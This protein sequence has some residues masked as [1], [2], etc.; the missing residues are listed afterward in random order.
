M[1]KLFILAALALAMV[2]C[3]PKEPATWQEAYDAFMEQR[4][5]IFQDSTLTEDQQLD[6][7]IE[8][9]LKTMKKHMDDTLG[10][11]L[12]TSFAMNDLLPVEELRA[13]YEKSPDLI[14]E[15]DR[16]KRCV[17]F[18]D[19]EA[20]SQPGKPFIDIAGPDALSGEELSIAGVVAQGKP[21]IIDF[22]ASWCQ[23]CRREIKGFLLNVAE[24]SKDKV[25]I[26]G[27]AV[28]ENGLEDTVKAMEELG[29]SWP[30]IFAGG[31]ENSPS[32]LYCVKGIPTMVGIAPDGTIV[33]KSHSG[34]DVF[35]ALEQYIQ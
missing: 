21:V 33:A 7:F 14:H 6:K 20:N 16:I 13:I 35:K 11:D 18:W 10:L 26:L 32:E 8:I 12:F 1:K 19:T 31:R 28:W 27:I 4:N 29:I 34:E 3:G 24:E 17:A 9:G 15:N 5:A 22:W 30:V 23:P 25:N 2:S